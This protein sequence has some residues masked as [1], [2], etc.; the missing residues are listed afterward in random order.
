MY[1]IHFSE[2]IARLRREKKITQEQLADFIGVTKASV[3][4]WETKQSMPDV[5][6]LPQLAAYFDVTIDELLGYEPQLSKEQIKKIYLELSGCIATE[7]FDCVL[8][9]CRELVKQYYS[10]YEFL[11]QMVTLWLNHYMLLDGEKGME[12]L[13]EAEALCRHILANCKDIGL[14]SDAL[15]LKASVCLAMGKTQQVIEELEE[16]SNPCRLAAESDGI[17]ISAYM[18]AGEWEKAN[19]FTQ[20]SMYGHLLSLVGCG[21]K[22]MSMHKD[23]LALC[24]ETY[25]RIQNVAEAFHLVKLNFNIMVLV[26]YQMAIIYSLHDRKKEAI[27]QLELFVKPIVEFL[28]GDENPMRSDEYLDTLDEWFEQLALGGNA[29]RDKRVV[30]DSMMSVFETPVFAGLK[31]EEEYEKLKA[32]AQKRGEVK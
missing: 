2:N 32:F 30:Y 18:S 9:R 25:R 28:N 7:D 16:I 13:K 20:I 15:I 31:G 5:I 19:S 29:P 22:Y 10:C 14:C 8:K 11:I 27:E 21:T 23:E 24:E 6:L 3:S 26:N 17:L 4:K 1:A 12:L